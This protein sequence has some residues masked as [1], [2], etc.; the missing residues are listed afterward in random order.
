[1]AHPDIPPPK[2]GT[3][4]QRS[5]DPVRAA[6]RICQERNARFTFMRRAVFEALCEAG[7]PLGAYDVM[8]R[9]SRVLNKPLGP[10]TVYRA[11]E[12]LLKHR[13]IAR[14]E[15]R[16][17]FVP[18]TDPSHRNGVFFICMHCG[19]AAGIADSAIENL[20]RRDAAALGFEIGRQVVELQGSCANCRDGDCG[21]SV[22]N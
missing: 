16:N 4:E 11:L 3:S 10:T 9:L 13:L 15:S 1:M 2:N 17:A 21:Q 8:D 7:R 22:T 19:S 6:E 12:F 5:A 18:N 14:I 20:L